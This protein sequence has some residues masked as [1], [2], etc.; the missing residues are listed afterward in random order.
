MTNPKY[1]IQNMGY[2]SGTN[3]S[4]ESVSYLLSEYSKLILTEY[5]DFLLKNGYVD[6]DVYQEPPSAIDRFMHPILNK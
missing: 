4:L 2:G 1:F 5:T 3:H 6:T